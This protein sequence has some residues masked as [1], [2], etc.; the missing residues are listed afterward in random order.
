MKTPLVMHV[1]LNIEFTLM[2]NK[3]ND[4]EMLQPEGDFAKTSEMHTQYKDVHAQRPVIHRLRDHSAEVQP[5]GR[6]ESS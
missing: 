4:V 6:M 3:N 2:I 1:H 5:E